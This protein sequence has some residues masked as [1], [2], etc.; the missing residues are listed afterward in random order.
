MGGRASD[1]SECGFD[2]GARLRES[3][4][5]IYLAVEESD[6]VVMVKLGQLLKIMESE[7]ETLEHSLVSPV[8]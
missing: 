4:A 5:N 3:K 8:S 6:D 1:D 7:M 2:F